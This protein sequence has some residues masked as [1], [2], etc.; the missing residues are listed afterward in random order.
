MI[1]TGPSASGLSGGFT[2][3]VTDANG[4]TNESDFSLAISNCNFFPFEKGA[5]ENN[6]LKLYPNPASESVEVQ[7]MNQEVI[8]QVVIKDKLGES[9]KNLSFKAATHQQ[10]LDIK[11]LNEGI[12]VL[13]LVTKQGKRYTQ[14][15]L[16]K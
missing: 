6:V 16:V 3:R 5:S 1:Q 8:Q 7:L 4:C 2:V 15:L 9:I 12:Y 10:K 14:K 13:E 11:G